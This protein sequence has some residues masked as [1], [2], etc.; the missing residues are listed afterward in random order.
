MFKFRS[1]FVFE[2]L[3]ENAFA[4][5]AGATGV[6]SLDDEAFDVSVENRP[7]VITTCAK[8]DE[9][10]RRHWNLLA[11]HLDLDITQTGV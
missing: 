7:V 4:A 1:N 3:I 2:F 6:P 9:I 5:F 8:R 10:L 11:E